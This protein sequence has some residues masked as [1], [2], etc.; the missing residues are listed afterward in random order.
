MY[1]D[2]TLELLGDYYISNNIKWRMGLTFEQFVEMM[3]HSTWHKLPK[4][5]LM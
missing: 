2:K 1:A 4:E 5:S 3:V